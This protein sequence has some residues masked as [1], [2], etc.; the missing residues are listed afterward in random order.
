MTGGVKLGAIV[1]VDT[2]VIIEGY[3]TKTWAALTGAFAIETVEECVAETQT[4]F[5][6]RPREQ[7]INSAELRKSLAAVHEVT[8]LE[9]VELAIRLE[10]IALDLGEESLLAH[11]WGRKDTWFLSGPDKASLRAAVRLGFRERLVSVEEL[12]QLAGH[13]S[14]T[15]LRQAYTKK[16][17]RRVVSEMAIAELGKK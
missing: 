15:V 13:R 14:R 12:L 10:G 1:L 6:R 9:S 17:T 5:Q 2:N 11:A 3:R 4:G 7:W 16:W 8:H